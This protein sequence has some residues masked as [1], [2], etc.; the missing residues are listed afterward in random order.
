M[1][2]C[3]S[4][5][6][7]KLR[8][9]KRFYERWI[10]ESIATPRRTRGALESPPPR[11]RRGGRQSARRRATR[12]RRCQSHRGRLDFLNESPIL[13]PRRGRGR[14]RPGSRARPRRRPSSRSASS[15]VVVVCG[16]HIRRA[17]LAG[18]WLVPARRS[19]R[20][21]SDAS[22]RR[23]PSSPLRV[24]D[25]P[26]DAREFRARSPASRPRI[27]RPRRRPRRR[28][29]ARP[30]PRPPRPPHRAH[31]H[32]RTVGVGV[33]APSPPRRSLAA[34]RLR[35][36]P[37][38]PPARQLQQ[39]VLQ[40]RVLRRQRV[41]QPLQFASHASPRVPLERPLPRPRRRARRAIRLESTRA[42]RRFVVRAARRHRA[43]PSRR[44]RVHARFPDRLRAPISTRARATRRAPSCVA[45][46]RHPRVG[47]RRSRV[48]IGAR[49]K[50]R[51]SIGRRTCARSR[52]RVRFG[53]MCERVD[54]EKRRA[55]KKKNATSATRRDR[56]YGRRIGRATTPRSTS[57]ARHTTID[58]ARAIARVAARAP[59]THRRRR[60]YFDARRRAKSRARAL[61]A[62]R[63]ATVLTRADDRVRETGA[64]MEVNA[65]STTGAREARARGDRSRSS[66]NGSF[67]TIWCAATRRRE[68]GDEGADIKV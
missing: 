32:H 11:S 27:I 49:A 35:D 3:C 53:A 63:G 34:R 1:L 4:C 6:N 42:S 25:S 17:F 18:A 48:S 31:G 45:V 59:R 13:L 51:V 33:H 64:I 68:N 37:R 54:G 47:P 41:R 14:R 30:A 44:A 20:A 28:L 12:N 50:S 43:S 66:A 29:A 21:L 26:R 60:V 61:D 10:R 39:R 22:T 7:D 23:I 2:V 52:V 5:C 9:E 8:R 19:K 58:R 65:T 46:G 62:T 67:W 57:R 24:F 16:W 40:H 55:K 56:G 38:A 36:S 15:P